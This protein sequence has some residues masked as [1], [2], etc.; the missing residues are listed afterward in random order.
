MAYTEV[1]KCLK[2]SEDLALRAES[3]DAWAA[4]RNEILSQ[5]QLVDG[6]YPL[7][8]SRASGAYFWDVDGNRY[9]DYILG[10][11]TVILG[12]ADPR[13]T[14][15]AVR[16]LQTGINIS[17]L[18]R[19]TQVDLAE[20]LTEVIP[21]AEMV[22]AMRTGSDATSGAIRLARIYTGRSKVARW[23]YNGWHDWSCSRLDGIPASTLSE[24]L[25]F[26][27]N[28]IASL[29]SLFQQHPKDIACV[30]MMSF[31]VEAPYP[32]FLQEV[33]EV[34]HEYG[35]L[36]ILDEMRSGFRMAL[37][38]AQQYF[39]VEADL[40]TYSKAIANGYPISAIV[41]RADVL[42]CVGRTHM[43]S[44][45][46]CNS[47]EM[48]AAIATI[49]IL[50]ES[51]AIARVWNLG[52]LL[53][54]GLRDLIKQYDIEGEVVGFPPCPFLMFTSSDESR[55]QSAKTTFYSATTLGGV[56]LHPN[57]HWFLSAAH[58]EEDIRETLDVCRLACEAVV[59]ATARPA[60]R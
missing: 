52:E 8:A 49:S 27:Y 3:C 1:A 35:A 15:A 31:E 37:G 36:F 24:T 53:Q 55:R 9:I 46:Y 41:G 32:G 10:Y 12:H 7:Y 18:W 13:V 58:T 48:A 16:E 22:F 45:Y 57:H 33:K 29:R 39:G 47:A 19:Q 42:R 60:S 23:G 54:A 43:A 5:D 56:F 30:I 40:A 51:G 4:T 17:P 28:D 34:A 44:T 20:L 2:R 11:G 50:R 25:M 26:R 59:D 38:G 6:A 14:D 21:G